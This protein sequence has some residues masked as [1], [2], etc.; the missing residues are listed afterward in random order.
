M[1]D[2]TIKTREDAI[3]KMAD[4]AATEGALLAHLRPN[5]TAAFGKDAVSFSV[6]GIMN[7]RVKSP[8]GGE[9]IVMLS[10]KYAVNP[11]RVV[12]RIA[13]GGTF[14]PSKHNTYESL[15]SA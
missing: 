6:Y 7:Y 2:A 12:G 3:A 10:T 1:M 15:E 14:A 5:L 4:I 13:I 9:D 8:D 11:E